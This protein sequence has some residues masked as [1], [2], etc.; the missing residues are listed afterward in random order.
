MKKQLERANRLARRNARK[1]SSLVP[2]SQQSSIGASV[3]ASRDASVGAE[4]NNGNDKSEIS[5]RSVGVEDKN[6]NC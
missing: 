6:A 1:V 5:D 4:S 2:H 3:A